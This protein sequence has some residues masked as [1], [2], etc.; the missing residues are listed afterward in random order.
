MTRH[1]LHV[2]LLLGQL[3]HVLVSLEVVWSERAHLIEDTAQIV[4]HLLLH[5]DALFEQVD[6]R[7]HE[8]LVAIEDLLACWVL[9]SQARDDS[10]RDLQ[11]DFL[12]DLATNWFDY[13]C[14]ERRVDLALVVVHRC[15][16]RLQVLHVPQHLKRIVERQQE[17][18]DLVRA[19]DI[20]HDHVEDER[21][22]GA[23]PVHKAAPGRLHGNLLPISHDLETAAQVPDLTYFTLVEHVTLHQIETVLYDRAAHEVVAALMRREDRGEQEHHVFEELA[24]HMPLANIRNALGDN[25]IDDLVRVSID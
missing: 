13:L 7:H 6:V 4:A 12:L 20:A 8:E 10:L 11:T 9:L 25:L 19:L 1:D 21:E 23:D 14:A 2:E 3:T 22:Q 17:V 18:V 24:L 15:I 5:V 16:W